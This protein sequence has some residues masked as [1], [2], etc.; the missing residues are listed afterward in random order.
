MFKILSNLAPFILFG[1]YLGILFFVRGK[2]PDPPIFFEQL[3]NFYMTYGY[4]LIFIAALFES[5]LLVGFYVPG[6]TVILLGA[7]VSKTGVIEL[8]LVIS[9]G[10]FGLILGYTLDYFIG[11]LGW[12]RLLSKFGLEQKIKIIG[13]GLM[14]HKMRTILIGFFSPGSASFLSTAAGVLKIPF[15]DFFILA[16]LAQSIWGI[17]WGVLAYSIG[18]ELVD[19][20][21]KYSPFVLIGVIL[22]FILSKVWFKFKL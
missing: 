13:E 16:V 11:K 9:I 5:M 21:F 7:A 1:L 17:F 12:V 2:I 3:K 19:A 4:F 20:L 22:L 14:K 18:I 10:I 15:K 8:P 6:S